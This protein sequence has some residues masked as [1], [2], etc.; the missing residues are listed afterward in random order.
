ME[1]Q[2]IT[3]LSAL[4][5]SIDFNYEAMRSELDNKLE[6]YRALVVTEDGIR[7]AKTDRANLNKLSAAIDARRKDIKAKFMAPYNDFDNKCKELT[8][9]IGQA[10]RSIDQQV[11][12]FEEQEKAEKLAQIQ[13]DYPALIGWL[14][15]FIPFERVMDP[16]WLNKSTSL[17]SAKKALEARIKSITADVDTIQ[18]MHLTH[19]TAVLACYYD[20]LDLSAAMAEN[21]R[22]S[23]LDLALD[24]QKEPVQHPEPPAVPQATPIP[25]PASVNE[26]ARPEEPKT[27]KVI[28]YDTTA[29]F[30]AEMRALTDKY[31]VK[32][33]GIR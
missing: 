29:A 23:K 3:D 20:T 10:S 2:I 12:A 25:E 13:A 19:E 26:P 7:D 28:F 11:K 15:T 6:Q 16:K 24:Q 30:R 1:F 4:P 33:G 22:L 8:G 27:I 21:L 9:M 18:N 31:G 32:Y 17:A 14:A 5:K